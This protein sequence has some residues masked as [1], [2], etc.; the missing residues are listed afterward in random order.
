MNISWNPVINI[1][2]GKTTFNHIFI[3]G[4]TVL[5]SKYYRVNLITIKPL[6]SA[7]TSLK[8]YLDLY[9][10]FLTVNR[11]LQGHSM[12]AAVFVRCEA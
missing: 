11:L 6:T 12:F 4:L 10:V 3:R 8:F 2:A 5:K 1:N 7:K 9:L